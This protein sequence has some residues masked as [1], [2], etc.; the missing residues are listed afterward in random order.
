[1][2]AQSDG[3][4]SLP[5]PPL[6]PAVESTVTETLLVAFRIHPKS[7]D[8]RS[9]RDAAVP[10]VLRGAPASFYSRLK[11]KTSECATCIITVN[12]IVAVVLQGDLRAEQMLP[13]QCDI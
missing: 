9:K 13:E 8:N 1:M 10:P 4:V 12:Y 6:P 7:N 2:E 11:R 3:S 5:P